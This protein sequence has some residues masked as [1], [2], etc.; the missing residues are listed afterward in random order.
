M[1]KLSHALIGVVDFL[2]TNLFKV[3]VRVNHIV[4]I[5]GLGPDTESLQTA[6]IV[7]SFVMKGAK[8]R[9]NDKGRRHRRR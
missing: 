5:I 3:E 4:V 8:G 9:R 1:Q 6:N 7:E 2:R